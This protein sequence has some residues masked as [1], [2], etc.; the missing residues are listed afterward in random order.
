MSHPF[1]LYHSYLQRF[2]ILLSTK[3]LEDK[4]EASQIEKAGSKITISKGKLHSSSPPI[5]NVSGGENWKSG[6]TVTTTDQVARLSF[7]LLKTQGI[8]VRTHIL[9][10]SFNMVA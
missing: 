6:R 4:R 1:L 9:F 3:V 7:S 2:S 8:I 5:H 10:C